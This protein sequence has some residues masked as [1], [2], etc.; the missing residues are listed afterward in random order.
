[1]R[2]EIAAHRRRARLVEEGEPLV[3]LA[4]LDQAAPLA[5]EREHLDVAASDPLPQLVGLVEELGGTHEV[6]LGEHR[7]QRVH[8]LEPA[9]LGSFREIRE[10]TLGAREPAS[11]DGE[12]AAAFVVPAQRQSDSSCPEKV[13]VAPVG[14]VRT[15]PVGDGFLDL[16]APPRGLADSSRDRRRSGRPASTSAYAA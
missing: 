11:C 8:E 6:A 15:L 3:D 5:G 7:G 12:R 2:P 4:G 14:G 1:M 13:A 10:Q 9:V 16:S